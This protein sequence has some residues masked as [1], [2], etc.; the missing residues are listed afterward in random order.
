M[1]SGD[2]PAVARRKVRLAIK[3][4]RLAK[5]DTQSVVA[6]A[7][8]WSLSKVMRI[9]SGEVT[10]TQNDLRPL[11]AYLGVKDRRLVED[12]VLAAKASKQRRQWWQDKQYTGMLTPAMAQLISFEAEAP[13]IRYFSAVAVPGPLQ[14]EGYAGGIMRQF[15]HE[16]TDEQIAARIEV[17]ARRKAALQQREP[18]PQ[19]FVLFDESVLLRRIGGPA[20]FTEQVAEIS[21]FIGEG[22]VSARIHPLD[23]PY[24]G[25]GPFELL[26]LGT[27]ENAQ[28]VLY[29]ESLTLDEIIDEQQRVAQ[30]LD[31]WKRM[32]DASMNEEESAQRLAAL[33]GTPD[34]PVA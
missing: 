34:L 12:L 21:R 17:R 19:I 3:D 2:T 24:P 9:E 27:E 22:W 28:G 1:S 11:L 26:Y 23:N 15:T 32:W 30:H 5:G 31:L 14:T 7:M 18:R 29:R 10:I 25:L 8:D 33:A 20:A 13:V 16:L 4:A 6:E